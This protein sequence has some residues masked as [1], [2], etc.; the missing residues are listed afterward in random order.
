MHLVQSP[1]SGAE[2]LQPLPG[3][4]TLA[5]ERQEADLDAQL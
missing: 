4:A 3:G 5:S 1:H 2:L